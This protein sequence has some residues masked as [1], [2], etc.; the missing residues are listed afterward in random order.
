MP[1]VLVTG[2]AGFLGFNLCKRLLKDWGVVCVD[3]LIT[4]S[5]EHL[6][7]LECDR[8]KYLTQNI[9]GGIY[10]PYNI[11]Q[12]YHLASIASPKWYMKHPLETLDAGYGGTLSCLEFA[13]EEKASFL[14]ASSS[15]VYGDPNET[16]QTESYYGNVNPVGPRACYDESKRVGETITTLFPKVKSHIARI[17]NTYGPGMSADDGRVIPEFI[18]NAFVNKPLVVTGGNQTRSFCYV[19]D[20]VEGLIKLMNSDCSLANLGN[21]EEIR[22]IDLAKKI[23]KLIGSRSKIVFKDLPLNDPKRRCPDISRAKKIGWSP[24]VSLDEGLEM[25][26]EYFRRL[27]V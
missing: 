23:I 17:F 13:L 16:P 19:D 11:R 22:I 4:G 3:N 8:F 5:Q 10:C 15:E 21:P 20:M 9:S 18:L 1:N 7:M 26:I 12:V 24:K 2:G 14:F 6:D 25:T 27:N